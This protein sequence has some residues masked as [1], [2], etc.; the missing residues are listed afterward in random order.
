[1]TYGIDE[2]TAD[3]EYIARKN[4]KTLS[5]YYDKDDVWHQ[6]VAFTISKE[7]VQKFCKHIFLNNKN[8]CIC[9]KEKAC[10]I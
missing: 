2:V 9:G 1:M 5:G 7:A 6:T 8:C 3:M 4:P 10:D